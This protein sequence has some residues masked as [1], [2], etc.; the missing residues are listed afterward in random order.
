MLRNVCQR[1]LQNETRGMKTFILFYFDVCWLFEIVASSRR[2]KVGTD[3]DLQL[4]NLDYSSKVNRLEK[5]V[6]SYKSLLKYRHQYISKELTSMP[7][8]H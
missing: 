5:K 6:I 3:S 7:L 4:Y 8:G 2:I 1:L